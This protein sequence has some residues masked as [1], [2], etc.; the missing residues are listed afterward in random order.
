MEGCEAFESPDGTRSSA[1]RCQTAPFAPPATLTPPDPRTV[2][3]TLHLHWTR[4]SGH[5]PH[6]VNR[7]PRR[8][9]APRCCRWTTAFWSGSWGAKPRRRASSAAATWGRAGAGGAGVI[10]RRG[11][12]CAAEE[13]VQ[14]RGSHPRRADHEMLC[15]ATLCDNGGPAARQT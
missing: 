10:Q 1:P 4:A 2:A 11:G 12:P 3:R 9:R 13:A 7:R 5:G 15:P 8:R 6:A 14:S